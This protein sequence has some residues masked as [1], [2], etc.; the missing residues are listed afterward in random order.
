MPRRRTLW[1]RI[2]KFLGKIINTLK[3]IKS[4]KDLVFY[5]CAGYFPLNYLISKITTFIN[6]PSS[7]A[8]NVPQMIS[9]QYVTGYITNQVPVLINSNIVYTNIQLYTPQQI[10]QPSPP[11][12]YFWFY[13]QFQTIYD[14]GLVVLAMVML[15]TIAIKIINFFGKK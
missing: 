8:S 7:T 10:Q 13:Y 11:D 9:T 3:K 1:S 12:F 14:F 5:I 6:Q 4:I 2:D 15:F